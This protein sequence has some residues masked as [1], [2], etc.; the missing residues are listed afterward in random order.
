MPSYSDHLDIRNQGCNFSELHN[1]VW[2]GGF[3]ADKD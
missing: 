2:A 1:T 3:H